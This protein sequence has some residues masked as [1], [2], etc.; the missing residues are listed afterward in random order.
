M[1]ET[2]APNAWDDSSSQDLRT[3]AAPFR[4]LQLTD[5]HLF[6]VSERRLLGQD[7]QR[8][9]ESVL[10]LAQARHWPPDAIVLSGDL[11]HDTEPAA[12]RFLRERF[13]GLGVPYH[14]IPGNHDRLDLLVG[15]LDASAVSGLRVV[16]ADAWDLLLLDSTIPNEAGGHLSDSVLA[17]LA[18]HRRAAGERPTLVFLH[19]HLQPLGSRWI[20]TMQ[21][22]NGAAALAELAQ[23]PRI[24]AVICGHVH[25][26]AEQHARGLRLLATPS[27]CVQFLPGSDDFALDSRTPGYRWLELYPDGHLETGIVR[28]D[29][30]PEP[31]TL[32]T[33]GY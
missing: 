11:V 32:V 4:L 3:T 29:A 30:Y 31:L 25:Q 27:T 6:G 8:T 19:H 23:N 7:T 28:T 10:A 26:D 22:D 2:D 24:R 12:Y 1:A 20:D 14:C 15:H 17:G 5:L 13:S 21:V 18:A 16:A 9:L 33:G